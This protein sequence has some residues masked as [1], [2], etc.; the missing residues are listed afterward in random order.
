MR[1]TGRLEGAA[2]ARL[3]T[4]VRTPARDGIHAGRKFPTRPTTCGHR[5]HCQASAF[6]PSPRKRRVVLHLRPRPNR[7]RVRAEL[8]R[9]LLLGSI[10]TV[11]SAAPL[12]LRSFSS[13]DRGRSAP[14]FLV[15][16]AARSPSRLGIRGNR[17]SRRRSLSRSGRCQTGRLLRRP[18]V[19]T[20]GARRAIGSAEEEASRWEAA[21]AKTSTAPEQTEIAAITKAEPSHRL[22]RGR[23]ALLLWI[24]RDPEQQRGLHGCVGDDGEAG[25]RR[26]GPPLR[27]DG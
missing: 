1:P 11:A 8:E 3:A 20:A 9:A 7:R 19:A 18:G 27:P 14:A 26:S 22:G 25:P 6:V 4:P 13:A 10:P 23:P 12:L 15:R 24:D 17:S 2:R 16:R 5:R 21:T